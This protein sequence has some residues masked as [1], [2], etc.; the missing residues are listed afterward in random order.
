MRKLPFAIVVAISAIIYSCDTNQSTFD[1][2]IPD[3]HT[4]TTKVSPEGSG[5]VHPDGGEYIAGQGIRIEARPAEGFIFYRWEDDLTGSSNPDSL[6]FNTNRTVTALFVERDYPLTI[7]TIGEGFVRE[8]ILDPASDENDTESQ[9]ER[10]TPDIR[11]LEPD[12]DDQNIHDSVGPDGEFA[13]SAPQSVNS[14]TTTPV[15]Q[16]S[17]VTVQ[18]TAEAYEGWYFDRW[19]GSLTGSENPE[20]IVVDE[21]KNVTAVFRQ[22]DPQG[23]V[24]DVEVEGE[25][26]VEFDPEQDIYDEEEEITVTAVAASGWIFVEWQGN[27]SGSDNPE[28][29]IMN[30][31]KNI[32]AIFE[33]SVDPE[34]EILQQPTNTTAGNAISPAPELRLLDERGEPLEGAEVAV[35]L[36]NNSFTSGSTTTVI[37]N[38]N[39]I[40]QFDNLVIETAATGYS[41][42]FGTDDTDVSDIASDTFTIRPADADASNSF[43]DVP[44]GNAGETTR[45]VIT[46][47]DRFDN[48]VDDISDELTVTVSGANSD[49]PSVNETDT[50]GEYRASYTPGNSGSDQIEIE[51]SG[52]PIDGSPFTSNVAAGEVSA[53]GSSA[54]ASPDRLQAGENSRVTVELQD[55]NGNSIEG[56][57]DGDFS[58]SVSGSASAGSVSESSGGTYQFD[59]T[60][61]AAGN[62]TVTITAGDVTLD[63]TP[64]IT[65]EA[66]EAFEIEITVQPEDSESGQPVEGPPTVRVTDEY[67]NAIPDIVVTANARGGGTATVSGDNQVTTDESG[68]AEFDNFIIRRIVGNRNYSLEFSAPGLPSVTSDSFEISGG[69]PFI[70]EE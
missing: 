22:H 68:V 15:F 69:F 58:I 21:E 25:G 67:G 32:T 10:Y 3:L 55:E 34:M 59:V 30:E 57:N 49:S 41:L 46:V 33:E 6:F 40:A 56:F 37:T 54:T 63:D 9:R 53:S 31:D 23:F 44:D 4:L 8:T 51:L 24:I 48:A 29:I 5:S 61:T 62:V 18:L 43:A 42:T 36:N 7:E 20:N 50:A 1:D 28:T 27:L 26:T 52:S 60:N 16:N 35:S 2:S 14:N 47:R 65:F 19:E 45:I 66:A 38:D 17:S 11:E 13:G 64:V 39:G 70:E 12:R